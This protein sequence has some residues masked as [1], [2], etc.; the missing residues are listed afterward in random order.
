MARALAQHAGSTVRVADTVLVG[1]V[2][3]LENDGSG[4]AALA[5]L[6]AFLRSLTT[7]ESI[8]TVTRRIAHPDGSFA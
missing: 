7:G 2:E 1:V 3:R 6:Q 4:P 8:I 5:R